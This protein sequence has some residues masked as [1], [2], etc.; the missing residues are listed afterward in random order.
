M[1]D[2]QKKVY[3]LSVLFTGLVVFVIWEFLSNVSNLVSGLLLSDVYFVI[4]GAIFSFGFFT[5]SVSAFMYLVSNCTIIK[6]IFF[7]NHYI[8][9]TWIGFLVYEK[10]KNEV[11]FTIEQI[12]QTTNGVSIHGNSFWYSFDEASESGKFRR[13]GRW[14]SQGAV[15]FDGIK[16]TYVALSMNSDVETTRT[17][18]ITYDFSCHGMKIPKVFWG[19]DIVYDLGSEKGRSNRLCKKEVNYVKL[20]GLN[21]AEASEEIPIMILKN[22]ESYYLNNQELVTPLH[23]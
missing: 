2:V 21:K 5:I 4:I 6:K 16:L 10:I 13:R 15:F 12:Q 1:Y 14:E 20:Y 19:R 23:D 3:G 18:V 9:G 17:G 7:S 8:E 11:V 22:M